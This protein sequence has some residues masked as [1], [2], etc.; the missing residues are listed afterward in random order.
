MEPVRTQ[1]QF[2]GL[3]T[4]GALAAAALALGFVTNRLRKKGQEMG[5]NYYIPGRNDP[6]M[7]DVMKNVNTVQM[8]ELS[9][10][11][12][13]AARAR[14]SRERANHRLDLEEVELPENHPW[15]TRKPMSQE[16]EAAIQ[17]RL[18]VKPRS[19]RGGPP[20][21]DTRPRIARQPGQ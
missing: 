5:Y 11:I 12:I 10:E 13:A 3:S 19:S 15:A 2:G 1:R 4:V 20:A 21:G 7:K 6:F 16:Q 14:R 8:D 18:Q 17:A 9:P